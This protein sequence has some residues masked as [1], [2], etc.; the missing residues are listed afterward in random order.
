MKICW[1]GNLACGVI[2]CVNDGRAMSFYREICWAA[3]WQVAS[4]CAQYGVQDKVSRQIFPSHLPD[5]W[6]GTVSR[7][8]RGEVV[9][10]ISKEKWAK[11]RDIV[12]E[13]SKMLKD[14]SKKGREGPALVE[15]TRRTVG[16]WVYR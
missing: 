12:R 7:T 15:A 16:Q 6:A 2:L 5:P 9:G 1:D 10:L 13:M 14:A 8:D 3:A 11:T 4:L